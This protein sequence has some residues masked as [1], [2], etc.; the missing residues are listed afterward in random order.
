MAASRSG[1]RHLPAG[2]RALGFV[3]LL[4]VFM[5]T[6]LGASMFVVVLLLL[7]PAPTPERSLNR[8]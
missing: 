3:S 4:P 5:A 6:S 1:L 7:R 2:T 8:A